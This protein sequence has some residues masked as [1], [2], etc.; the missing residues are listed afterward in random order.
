[1]PQV[2]P[3]NPPKKQI[4]SEK[5]VAVFVAFPIDRQCEDVTTSGQIENDFQEITKM[6]TQSVFGIALCAMLIN[7]LTSNYLAQ[8][9]SA[10]APG[11]AA[12]AATGATHT[13]G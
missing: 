13:M 8:Q 3:Q 10:A 6:K 12:S 7:G 11:K 5:K 2:Y 1:V 4:V 9:N